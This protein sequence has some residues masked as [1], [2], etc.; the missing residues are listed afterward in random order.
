MNSSNDFLYEKLNYK[1]PTRTIAKVINDSRFDELLSK[2]VSNPKLNFLQGS[3]FDIDDTNLSSKS[4]FLLAMNRVLNKKFDEKTITFL[5]NA[6]NK[7]SNSEEKEKILFWKYQLLKDENYL[8]ALSQSTDINIYT[9]YAKQ[10]LKQEITINEQLFKTPLDDYLVKC[11][12]NKKI[13]VNSMAKELSNFN[14]NK[15]EFLNLGILQVNLEYAQKI[16]EEYDFIFDYSKLFD[17][18][19]N[20][21][22]FN[23]Y[24]QEIETNYQSPLFQFFAYKDGVTN[25]E[26]S[27]NRDLFELKNPF[28]PYLSLE[29]YQNEKSK[30]F[31]K[32]LIVNYL[33]YTK[34]YKK[35]ELLLDNFLKRSTKP[36]DFLDF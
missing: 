29:I 13:I 33:I 9:I 36:L 26:D 6:Y 20:F 5:D 31:V 3:F 12:L 8:I 16:A 30:E 4:S 28:E 18:K 1:F 21:L 22:Y 23:I 11:S 15:I 2:I 14:K 35:E 17:I 34:I 25:F 10:F 27:L 32:N 19:E 24:F 7:S